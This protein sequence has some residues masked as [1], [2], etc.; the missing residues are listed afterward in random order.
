MKQLRI[1]VTNADGSMKDP[2]TIQRELHEAFGKMS[3]SEQILAASA[4]FVK[5]QMAP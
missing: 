5:N 3:E 2:V 4:I 1:E